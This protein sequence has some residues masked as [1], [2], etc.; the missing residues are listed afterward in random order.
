MVGSTK[1]S[2]WEPF[3]HAVAML[4]NEQQEQ[5]QRGLNDFTAFGSVLKSNDEVRLHTRFIHALLNP[6][7]KHYQG[8]LFLELFMD[9][10]GRPG[11]LDPNS[12][13]VR[14]EYCPNGQDDQIDLYITDGNREIVVENK[15]NAH[16]QPRQVIRYLDAIGA[17]TP[18]HAENTLFVYLTKSRD[19]PSP[20]GLGAAAG[21]SDCETVSGCRFLTL[22]PR[23]S[24]LLNERGEAIAQYQNLWY[25]GSNTDSSIHAWIDA[26]LRALEGLEAGNISWAL[27]D[28]KSIV[29]R[30]TGE[31][32]SK[33]T[34][35]KDFLDE[36]IALGEKHH[37]EA[38]RLARELP[39]IQM[40]W[41]DSAM[42]SHLDE[43]FT[44]TI[45]NG[46][47]TRVDQNNAHKLT[48]FLTGKYA[49][50][51]EQLLYQDRFNYFGTGRDL[52]NK[53][54]FFLVE[55]GPFQQRAVFTLFYGSKLLHVGCLLLPG[56][57]QDE[58]DHLARLGLRE[59][60]ASMLRESIFP[61]A[62]TNS[63][64]LSHQGI[65]DLAKFPSCPQ[66][67]L[68][69]LLIDKVAFWER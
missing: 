69:K 68:L 43:L 17:N 44:E 50:K 42:T 27:T 57:T 59:D 63:E 62:L 25:R 36:S 28:Y 40:E 9:C 20:L 61:G 13:V 12:T 8:T 1:N 6:E 11:W 2:G 32:V 54:S 30:A 15:L 34:T 52:K 16:D 7:G 64:P 65:I 31:Y 29:E 24:R 55:T 56:A 33:V 35:L 60:S 49:S 58:R 4:R 38:I 19:T 22:C 10:L 23:T 5:K 37:I 14:K 66:R 45:D 51:P 53:G 67:K 39:A 46:S 41:L 26:C 48:P 18:A 21:P 3:F 47:V